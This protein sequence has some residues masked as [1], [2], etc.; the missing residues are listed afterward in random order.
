MSDISDSNVISRTDRYGRWISQLRKLAGCCLRALWLLLQ[1]LR[2]I[3]TMRW[4]VSQAQS[5]IEE[6]RDGDWLDGISFGD[7]LETI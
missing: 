4:L 6:L 5:C 3:D 2:V 7:M 1:I